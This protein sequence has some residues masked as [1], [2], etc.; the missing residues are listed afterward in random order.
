METRILSSTGLDLAPSE[1]GEALVEE[2]VEHST[3]LHA[4]LGDREPYLVGPLARYALNVDGLS[5]IA[6]EEADAAGLG[7][8]C[9]NPFKS[10][11]VRSV[12][13]LHACDEALRLI[14]AY[15]RPDRPCIEAPPRA[16]TGH[17]CT[18]APRG[19]LYHRYT[20]DDRGLIADARIVPPTSQ[21]LRS[22]E[23][24]LRAFAESRLEL[25]KDE[26]TW[27]CEQAIRNYDPC[28]SCATHFLT[29][30]IVRDGARE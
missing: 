9:R 4:R 23:S 18:E 16:G 21:N 5:A 29:L 11:V 24:D 13:L 3:A 14:A 1:Y 15:E 25:S 22:I 20:L 12:E 30:E 17:G 8:V 28:I 27:Q 7:T 2:Q 10:I 6:R 26:L 19:I